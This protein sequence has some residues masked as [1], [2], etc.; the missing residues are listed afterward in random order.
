VNNMIGLC[1]LHDLALE[2]TMAEN[3]GPWQQNNKQT[4]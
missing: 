1:N 3:F 4:G 2:I